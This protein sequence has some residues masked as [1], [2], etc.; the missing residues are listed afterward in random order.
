M[1]PCPHLNLLERLCCA[2]LCSQ[3]PMFCWHSPALAPPSL[4]PEVVVVVVMVVT[5]S[6]LLVVVLTLVDAAFGDLLAM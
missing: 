5:P 3:H 4:L 6:F 1:G 2:V